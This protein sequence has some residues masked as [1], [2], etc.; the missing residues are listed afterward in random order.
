MIQVVA[1]WHLRRLRLPQPILLLTKIGDICQK[2]LVL[3]Q[4]SIVPLDNWKVTLI[5]STRAHDCFNLWKDDQKHSRRENLGSALVPLLL[6]TLGFGTCTTVAS[7]TV[8]CEI[9]AA[10]TL[11][12]P[13]FNPWPPFS[14][15]F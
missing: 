1:A 6:H 4:T 8:F 12:N 10:C 15:N 14:I 5:G 13:I 7:H 11:T 2:H 9:F 3:V